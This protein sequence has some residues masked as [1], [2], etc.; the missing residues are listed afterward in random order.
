MCCVGIRCF[1]CVR[2]CCV[3]VGRFVLCYALLCCVVLC[4]VVLC[5]AVLRY[6]KFCIV[7]FPVVL[8]VFYWVVF[9]ICLRVLWCP[10]T[11]QKH[12]AILFWVTTDLTPHAKS[13]QDKC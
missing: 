5:W 6:L 2:F 10:P 7:L 8:C 4:V 1:G 13:S 9:F 11:S 3:G 12:A